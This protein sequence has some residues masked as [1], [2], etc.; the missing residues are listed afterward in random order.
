[1]KFLDP[2]FQIALHRKILGTRMSGGRRVQTIDV[3]NS[4]FYYAAE[5]EY[6]ALSKGRI[7]IRIRLAVYE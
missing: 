4:D 3:P 2:A 1:M 5:Y 6:S 7:Q